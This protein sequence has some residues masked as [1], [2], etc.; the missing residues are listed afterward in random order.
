M[1]Y[2]Q[3][4]GM[5]YG[6]ILQ[7]VPDK[8][9]AGTLLVEIFSRLTPRL[10]VAFDSS[11][12]IYCWLQVE[13]RKIILEHGSPSS[14][15]NCSLL[16]DAPPEHQWVFRELF[17]HGRSKE[18]LALQSGRDLAHVSRLLRECLGMIRKNLG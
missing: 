12:S 3:Y 18:E 4:G 1:L 11:L 9:E 8:V 13:T 17:L 5:L 10:Q 16:Q 14:G 6:Y 15:S 7:F 2:M